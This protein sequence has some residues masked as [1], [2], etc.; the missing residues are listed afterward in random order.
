VSFAVVASCSTCALQIGVE[1]PTV[2]EAQDIAA[3][4][5]HTHAAVHD[6]PIG[7]SL[8]MLNG[9]GS[10]EVARWLERRAAS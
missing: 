5:M 6:V 3:K 2:R 10:C 1:S 9:P 4:E 7:K 8:F